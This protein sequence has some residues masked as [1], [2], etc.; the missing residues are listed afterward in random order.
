[1]SKQNITT[2]ILKGSIAQGFN[3][4]ARIAEQLLLVPVFLS[5][6]STALYG[7][8]LLISAVPVYF[9]L[10]DFGFVSAG[11]NE[12]ARRAR[13]GIT[14]SV[15]HFFI[16]YVSVFLNWS[17]LIF[18]IVWLGSSF[19]SF[20]QVFNLS[21]IDNRTARLTFLVLIAGT[22]LSQNGNSLL[23]GM[24]ATRNF[25]QGLIILAVA[26]FIRLGAVLVALTIFNA[27]PLSISIIILATRMVTF[28]TMA[29]YNFKNN[30]SPSWRFF[31]KSREPMWPLIRSGLEFMLLPTAQA[32]ILQGSILAIGTV[33]NATFVAVY[34]THRILSRFSSQIVQLGVAPLRAE[35]GLINIEKDKSA[36]RQLLLRAAS[37]TLWSSLIV[38]GSLLF[39]GQ[40]VFQAWTGGVIDFS[41][42]LFTLLLIATILEGLW[43]VT[44]SIRLGTNQHQLL[45]RGYLIISI[46]GIFLL[47][48]LL[49]VFGLMGAACA[50]IL[51]ESA[52]LVLVL[53]ANSRLLEISPIH[54][55]HTIARPPTQD[56]QK[57]VK[58]LIFRK[59]S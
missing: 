42:P 28:V 3:L 1:M 40:Y 4:I 33:T 5:T 49:N 30:L 58:R 22:F 17:L 14:Q 31:R 8:W 46:L 38:T 47:Y 32:I 41:S 13:D 2:R 9:A 43:R 16:D 29:Y 39:L 44:A 7:E 34:G 18:C 27:N 10:S 52:M 56:V 48:S 35:F 50:L 45:A 19:I 12:L 26:S 37:L 23:A 55:L 20:E 11:S 59:T 54:F 15:H 6:W 51:I 57:I 25:P 53:K 21:E 24:R 36:A